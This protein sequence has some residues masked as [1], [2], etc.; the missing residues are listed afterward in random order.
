MDKRRKYSFTQKLAIVLAVE[1][2]D[3]SVCAVARRFGC[4]RACIQQW[5]EHYRSR[6]KAGLELQIGLKNYTAKFRV[7]VIEEILNKGLSLMEACSTFG[8]SS[9]P[10]IY[11]WLRIY[12]REGRQGLLKLGRGPKPKP[13]TRKK[14]QVDQ[15]LTPE[16]QEL[17]ALKAENEWLRT[18]NAYLKKLDALMKEEEAQDKKKKKQKPSGN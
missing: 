13:M 2:E 6:G 7:E 10:T 8:I 11:N 5:L 9:Y 18:E 4:S 16:Q 17:A 1:D 12:K 14:L 3:E 15:H